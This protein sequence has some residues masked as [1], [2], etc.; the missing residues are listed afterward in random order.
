MSTKE[1][2]IGDVLARSSDFEQELD[3]ETMTL[4]MGPS[5]PSPRSPSRLAQRPP[6]GYEQYDFDIPVGPYFAEDAKK[7]FPPTKEKIMSSMEELIQN[8]MITTQ[9]PQMPAGEVYFEGENPN[10]RGG[11][12]V[13][14][15]E[16]LPDTHYNWDKKKDAEE[17]GN[18]H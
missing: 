14:F 15:I 3:T 13:G 4:S 8:F 12:S 7:I 1:I 11:L 5:H 9:G 17:T 18:P 6:S 10:V 2:S 16:T